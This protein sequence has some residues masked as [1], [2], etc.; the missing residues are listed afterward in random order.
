MKSCPAER[1][2]GQDYMV[3]DYGLPEAA[4]ARPQATVFGKDASTTAA[5]P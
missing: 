5:S 2:L 4:A 3:R 1:T